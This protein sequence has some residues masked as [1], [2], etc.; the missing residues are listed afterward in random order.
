MHGHQGS[1]FDAGGGVTHNEFKIHSD[2][3]IEYFFNAF[4]S[5]CVL[6]AG[7]GRRQ[8][9]QVFTLF[10]FDERLVQI[11]FTGD[12]VN[13]VIHHAAFATH[14]QVQVAQAHIKVDH[15][16]FVSAQGQAG[17]KTRAG[18]C[19]TNT[20]FTGSDHNYFCHEELSFQREGQ[21]VEFYVF[22]ASIII[23]SFPSSL[24]R[25]WAG[26]PSTSGPNSCSVVR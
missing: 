15:R 24:R 13:Q 26:L 12:H 8:N 9:I 17:C 3:V 21:C 7:L 1:G 5:Q 10:V 20:A 14:D 4:L 25:T 16:G 19:F 22:N 23:F 6:V 2:Q 18:R 11:G